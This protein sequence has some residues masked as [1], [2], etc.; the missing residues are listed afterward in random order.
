MMDTI[1]DLVIV[2]DTD[3][4]VLDFNR[5]ARVAGGLGREAAG[6]GRRCAGH[7]ESIGSAHLDRSQ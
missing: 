4:R 2:L 7:R 3:G 5:A 6:A 1:E